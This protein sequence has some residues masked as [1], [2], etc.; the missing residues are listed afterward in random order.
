MNEKNSLAQSPQRRRAELVATRIALRDV[1]RKTGTH[2]MELEVGKRWH[3]LSAQSGHQVRHLRIAQI[4][5]VA[6]GATDS[7][8]NS[9]PVSD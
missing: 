6:D 7:I 1:V 8:E 2:V 4:G 5:S 3:R 9:V